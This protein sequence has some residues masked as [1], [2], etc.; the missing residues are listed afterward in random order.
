MLVPAVIARPP[1]PSPLPAA[2]RSSSS[3]GSSSPAR[4]PSTG[5]AWRTVD[6]RDAGSTDCDASTRRSTDALHRRPPGPVPA[7]HLACHRSRDVRAVVGAF[8]GPGPA[9]SSTPGIR[10]PRSFTAACP[11]ACS[12]WFATRRSSCV[13]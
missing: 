4:S 12:A 6:H 5:P 8:T 11:V 3:T 9:G 10:T 1:S 2:C 13:A 7:R